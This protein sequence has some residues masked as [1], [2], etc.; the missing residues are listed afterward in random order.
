M[1]GLRLEAKI[2]GQFFFQ[3]S[4]KPHWVVLI[5]LWLCL[6]HSF[7]ARQQLCVWL[8]RSDRF[9]WRRLLLSR[10]LLYYKT[11][12]EM[13]DFYYSTALLLQHDQWIF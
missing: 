6:H 8:C 4:W 2:K 11:I 5:F 12:S 7:S 1:S 9:L 13:C 10:A 3:S